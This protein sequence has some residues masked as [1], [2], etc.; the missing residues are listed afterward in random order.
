MVYLKNLN[1]SYILLSFLPAAL[2]IGPF[3][4]EII[5]NIISVIFIYNLIKNKKFKILHTFFFKYFFAFYLFLIICFYSS[6][7]LQKL[8]IGTIFY[9][10]FFIFT[11]AA[12]CILK[13]N[14]KNLKFLN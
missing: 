6:P 10:R 4:A 2:V 8:Q 11:I 13:A 9:F 5:I 3:I 7:V 12:F 1:F 14:K